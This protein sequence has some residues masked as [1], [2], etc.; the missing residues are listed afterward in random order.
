MTFDGQLIYVRGAGA[1]KV[2]C[3]F[4]HL[5]GLKR[6]TT[7]VFCPWLVSFR[8]FFVFV[9]SCTSIQ[10]DNHVVVRMYVYLYPPKELECSLG[11]RAGFWCER[12][13]S[14]YDVPHIHPGISSTWQMPPGVL[15]TASI[16]CVR[17]VMCPR[18]C[19]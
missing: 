18:V 6:R 17:I 7:F 2:V 12:C 4:T 8:T 16:D 9:W 1:K 14:R 5:P 10:I 3:L 13:H 19:D 11:A 15:L